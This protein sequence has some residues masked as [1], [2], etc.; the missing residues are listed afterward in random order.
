MSLQGRLL[1][2]MTG[3]F[4]AAHLQGLVCGG[5][6]GRASVTSR[7]TAAVGRQEK[8]SPGHTDDSGERGDLGVP[9]SRF[10]FTADRRG[11]RLFRVRAAAT[12]SS[13][14]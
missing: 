14:T 5:E 11:A 2:V 12:T 8:R 4:Q 10:Q 13:N 7:P 1:A 3:C 6:P 9:V